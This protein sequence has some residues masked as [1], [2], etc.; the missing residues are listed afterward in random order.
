MKDL[1]IKSTKIQTGKYK[2]TKGVEVLGYITNDPTR[3]TWNVTK[4]EN[5][6]VGGVSTEFTKWQ[7]MLHFTNPIK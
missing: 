6:I 1:K 4:D 3:K 5:G 7:A 2:I